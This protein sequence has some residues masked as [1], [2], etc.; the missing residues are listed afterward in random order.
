M[1]PNSCFRGSAFLCQRA[2]AGEFFIPAS[3][4]PGKGGKHL[5][6]PP[7]SRY[8]CGNNRLV[9]W[10]GLKEEHALRARIWN[11][12]IGRTA[13]RP[14]FVPLSNHLLRANHEI[15]ASTIFITASIITVDISSYLHI[16]LYVLK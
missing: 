1:C 4:P 16:G 12:E 5:C 13:T 7:D 11:T 6:V 15:E 10:Q 2:F 9:L 8:W 3:V 14:Q